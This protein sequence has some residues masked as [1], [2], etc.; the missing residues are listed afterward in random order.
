MPSMREEPAVESSPI[1]SAIPSE[2]NI[3]RNLNELLYLSYDWTENFSDVQEI[4]AGR[5]KE[6]SRTLYKRPN[7]PYSD[8]TIR[9]P[10]LCF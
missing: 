4:N 9:F 2:M 5:L 8:L 6:K 10:R 1:F 7:D 3:N